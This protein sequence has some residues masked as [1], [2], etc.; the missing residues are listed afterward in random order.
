VA[1]EVAGHGHRP[2]DR[3]RRGGGGDVVLGAAGAGEG[4][5]GLLCRDPLRRRLRAGEACASLPR[6]PAVDHRRGDRRGRPGVRGRPD[7]CA[8]PRPTGHGPGDRPAGRGQPGAEPH[9]PDPGPHARPGADGRGRGPED[10]HGGRPCGPGPEAD[11]RGRRPPLHL[12][13][14]RRGP[15]AGIRLCPVTGIPDARRCAPGGVLGPAGRG[16]AGVRGFG[17]VQPRGVP[18]GAGR[19]GPGRAAGCRPAPVPLWRPLGLCPGGPA[20]PRLPGRRAEG[21]LHLG[22]HPAADLPGDRREP[23]P[24][25][26]DPAGGGGA[27]TDRAAQGVRLQRPG[28]GL[29]LSAPFGGHRPGGRPG[30]RPCRRRPRRGDRRDVPQVFPLPR[31]RRDLRL[32]DLRR[33]GGDRHPRGHG[34]IGAGGAPRGG[35]VTR[36]GHAAAEARRLPSGP[37]RPGPAG[38]R[39]RPG[40]ADD[41][42]PPAAVPGAGAAG[43]VRPGVEPR[44]AGG[45]PVPVRQHR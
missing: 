20:L 4:A 17:G 13:H 16:G 23:R 21:A 37:P 25:G 19:L 11:R 41:P 39:R 24:P 6:A 45:D 30:R 32:A 42:A 29:A 8:R 22:H 43:D 3:L 33:R 5:D 10:L 44:P 18:G 36:G 26:G 28:G 15:V 35:P 31:P 9:H 12:H 40:H 14:R 1:H 34:R 7:G 2:A 27:R 38:R